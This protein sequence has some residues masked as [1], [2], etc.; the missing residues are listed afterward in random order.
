MGIVT[1][2]EF[3]KRVSRLNS[4]VWMEGER[5]SSHVTEHPAF[6]AVLKQKA[7]LYDM[8]HDPEYAKLL[9]SDDGESNFSY[10]LPTTRDHLG[11]RRKATQVWARENAGVLGRSPE[12]VNTLITVLAGAKDYFAQAGTEYGE[13][14]EAIYTRAKELDLTFT[15]TFVNP[16]I[17]RKPF[18]PDGITEQ[19]IAAKIVEETKEGIVIDGA[20]LLA[21]QGGITD[22][23]LVLPTGAFQDSA[24]LYGFCIPSDTEGITFLSRPPFGKD[25]AYDYPLSSSFEEGDAIVVFDHVLVPWERVFLYRNEALTEGAL[26]ETGGEA[27]ILFQAANRQIAKTEWILGMAESIVDMLNIRQFQHVQGKVSEIIVALEAMRGFVY[28]AETQAEKNEYGFFVPKLAPMKACVCYYQSTYPRL[29]EILQLLGA[30]GFIAAPSEKD[31]DS[32]V[33][34]LLERFLRAE[35]HTAKEKVALLRLARDFS[36]S[37][38]G[39]RQTLYERYFFGDPVRTA[40]ALYYYFEKKPF[41]DWIASFLE[42]V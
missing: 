27:F 25:S 39:T 2:K 13:S 18:Y 8:V 14:I 19:A 41:T 23:V 4:T 32:P 21:T 5:V 24:Y 26:I 1:G 12:Y 7:A 28:S 20:R 37:E 33:G 36:M 30:S 16:P 3:L 31:F 11:K 10:E 35:H 34:K 9:Q 40:S 38:F 6:R 17:S 42:D 15:H 22:E 29:V